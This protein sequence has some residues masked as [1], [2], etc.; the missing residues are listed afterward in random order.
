M[1]SSSGSKTEKPTPERIKKAREQ[2]QFLTSKALIGGFQ[3]VAFLL[4]VEQLVAGWRLTIGHQLSV[5]LDRALSGPIGPSEWTTLIRGIF[6]PIFLPAAEAGAVLLALGIGTHF[7]LTKGGFSL[8][9]LTP[10]VERFNF[11]SKMRELPRQNLKSV[12]QATVLIVVL[13]WVLY[14]FVKQN[15]TV[16]L[17]LPLESV[18]A[19]AAEL[20]ASVTGLLW[21]SAFLFLAFGAIDLMQQYRRHTSRLRMSKE[22][23]K[24]ESKRSQGDP[25]LKGRIRR[26]RR[27]LLR[28]Q[29]MSEVPKATAVIV[30][31]THFAVAI[32]YDMEAMPCPVVTAKGRNW[33]ALRIRQVAIENQIPIIENPVLARALYEAIDV[34]R[35]ISPE[36]YKAIAEVLAYVYKLMGRKLPT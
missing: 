28:R 30:N 8:H 6:I 20:V 17:R 24:E 32:R 34:G 3:F 21:K 15:A 26:L 35:T 2:G 25:H 29:M 27:E 4:V 33:L 16:L 9:L 19:G 36:F 10:S 22:E 12:L 11:A 18:Q 23:I 1:A 14:S 13:S 5:M 31:P 7:L